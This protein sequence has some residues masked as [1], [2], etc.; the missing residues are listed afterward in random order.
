[1]SPSRGI[2]RSGSRDFDSGEVALS[3]LPRLRLH[4]R[5]VA[6]IASV[7]AF[8]TLVAGVAAVVLLR[9]PD[10]LAPGGPERSLVEFAAGD[11][12]DHFLH[13]QNVA[14]AGTLEKIAG[15]PSVTYA[16]VLDHTGKPVLSAGSVV[17]GETGDVV[18]TPI[19]V[20]GRSKAYEL[21]VGFRTERGFAG[22]RDA[23]LALL[24]GLGFT[25]CVVL[26]FVA[27]R[28]RR[29]LL[30]LAHLH[31]SIRRFSRGMAPEPMSVSG[32]DEVAYLS[33]A[34]N[35]MA[36]RLLASQTDMMTAN[37]KLERRVAE[38]THDLERA[39]RELDERNHALN[40]ITDNALRFAD[41]VAHE[42]R[43]PVAVIKEFASLMSEGV[44]GDV[45][46]KQR[47]YL[48]FVDTAASDLAHLLDDFLDSS[49]LRARALRVDR[50]AHPPS[51]LLDDAWP[52]LEARAGERGVLMRRDIGGGVPEVYADASKIRRVLI[53]LVVNAVKFSESGDT[54]TVSVRAT[55]RGDVRFV[56]RDQG[57]GMEP[58]ELSN[59]FER[60]RQGREGARSS[61]KGFGLGL[62]IVR[63]MV[64]VNLGVVS[65]ESEPGK[66]SEFSFDLPAADPERIMHAFVERA[67]DRGPGVRCAVLRVSGPNDPR[68]LYARLCEWMR[69][70]DLALYAD[71]RTSVLLIG[72][73]DDPDAWIAQLYEQL[74][75]DGTDG[76]GGLARIEHLGSWP[77][78]QLTS[79]LLPSL[80]V[81]A[82]RQE[83]AV[84]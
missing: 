22:F 71:D 64:D 44:A 5:F 56:V 59:L 15:Q 61:F 84:A 75:A 62:S 38:R 82:P 65:V 78:C 4:H 48:A 81:R 19:D 79:D 8:Q 66:G 20:P 3:R 55:E 1:M 54:V 16:R 17:E 77:A 25:L 13:P 58:E 12:S 6:V 42:F 76:V 26:P 68:E 45:N 32:A 60:F 35:N 29:W 34:F 11:L 7:A 80:R 9:S 47:R 36:G 83:A 10:P 21:V 37:A 28:V 57:K 51:V 52:M 39:N 72:E 74:R 46:D 69:P 70:H 67:R 2:L 14:A 43:T 50:R 53:N 49:R 24:C 41:D 33:A 73:S 31:A 27:L 40:E 63:A 18:R 23:G 30:G